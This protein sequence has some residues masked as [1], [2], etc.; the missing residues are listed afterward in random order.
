MD[1]KINSYDDIINIQQR[2]IKQIEGASNISIYNFVL[3]RKFR[4]KQNAYVYK[5]G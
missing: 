4:E 2:L 1:K 3:L 5:M